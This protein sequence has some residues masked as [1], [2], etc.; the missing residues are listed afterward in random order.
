MQ[1]TLRKIGDG[2]SF[3]AV[4][5]LNRL[6]SVVATQ[7][8]PT[9]SDRYSFFST[10]GL[11][12]ALATENWLPVLAQE[13]RANL[14]EREGYQ[15]H[16]I[17]F[18]QPGTV[19]SH[20]GDLAP[21]IILTNA[22]DAR[23]AYVLMAGFFRLVC[24]NGLIVSEGEFGAIHIRH[25]GYDEK[26]VIEASYKV[27]EDVPRLV[28]KI[29]DY[30]AIELKPSEK[31]ILAESALVLKY[32]E[33]QDPVNA[34]ANEKGEPPIIRDGS[35]LRIG[36]RAFNVPALL[37]PIREQEAPPTLWN[38]FNTIQEK[39]SKGN[40]FERTVR[41]A[42]DGHLTHRHKVKG[43]T[44]INEDIRFNRG[45]WNLME[46]MRGLKMAEATGTNFA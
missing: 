39:I 32:G 26:D 3:I 11:I 12:N 44:G 22:H 9:V 45:L 30:R 33:G 15:K 17:R 1:G 2:K 36:N 27:I 38:T 19:L 41:R 21:E 16:M 8:A 37:T 7:E 24:L 6:G 29:Q 40:K 31:E 46:R 42:P 13:Q 35:L 43:I 18:R 28:D 25:L 34:E 4:E 14:Q 20:V 23:A 5:S 10:M